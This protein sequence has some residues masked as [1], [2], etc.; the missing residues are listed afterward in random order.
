MA[1][2]C[3]NGIN[4]N[5]VL[6]FIILSI[7][8]SFMKHFTAF[9]TVHCIKLTST[10]LVTVLCR[11]TEHYN[12]T[13]LLETTC[14]K[15]LNCHYV[16]RGQFVA[17]F[18]SV[19]YIMYRGTALLKMMSYLP[20]ISQRRL[21]QPV[22]SNLTHQWATPYLRHGLMSVIALLSVAVNKDNNKHKLVEFVFY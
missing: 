16:T 7:C 3:S 13:C 21:K 20:I 4:D 1:L 19:E 22:Y 15:L 14:P 10:K 12:E 18:S 6:N 2:V 9:I 11:H 5:H 17:R 8:P